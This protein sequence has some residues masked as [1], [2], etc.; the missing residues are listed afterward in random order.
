MRV[1]KK[2]VKQTMEQEIL[3]EKIK[4][5]FERVHKKVGVFQQGELEAIFKEGADE[6]SEEE[7]TTEESE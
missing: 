1:K 5:A 3:I 7:E 4:Y 6:D 2:R